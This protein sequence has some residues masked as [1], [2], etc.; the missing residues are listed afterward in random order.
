MAKWW[1]CMKVVWSNLLV[2]KI[3]FVL[4]AIAP[5]FV[6]L[7]VKVSL[8]T[9]IYESSSASSMLGGYSLE[10]MLSYHLWIMIVT[11]VS[12]G[13]I[14]QDLSQ[15]I[16]MGRITIYLL[17]PFS[18]FEFHCA[19]F[20][21][22]QSVKLAIALFSLGMVIVILDLPMEFSQIANAILLSLWAGLFWF[23]LNYFFG[24]LGFWLE[25][26]WTFSVMI[27]VITYFFSGA[28]IPLEFYPKW[29]TDILI[30]TPFPYLGYVP[31]KIMMG[32]DI[33]LTFAF[34]VLG[35]W[36]LLMGFLTQWIFRRGIR[37]YTAAGM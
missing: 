9:A 21:A 17:V 1:Q 2:Y 10:Q 24:L 22:K 32:A 8:W 34:S 35:A 25:E 4:Q 19:S 3:N 11:L 15:D 23:F 18:L 37:L 6:F 26:T 7:F 36:M 28:I 29:L 13:A 33:D 14:N 16:R 12:L 20:L 31:A 5:L 30:Y 27:Q